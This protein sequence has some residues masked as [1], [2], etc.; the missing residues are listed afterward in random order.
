MDDKEQSLFYYTEMQS[1]YRMWRRRFVRLIFGSFIVNVTKLPPVKTILN[2]P[3]SLVI[4]K[5]TE[6]ALNSGI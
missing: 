3:I 4:Y 2:E 5:I 1:E 6:A